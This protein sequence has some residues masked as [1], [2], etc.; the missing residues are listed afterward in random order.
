MEEKILVLRDET[1]PTFWPG[2]NFGQVFMVET[3]GHDQGFKSELEYS[4]S[5]PVEKRLLLHQQALDLL[6]A[7]EQQR[8]QREQESKRTSEVTSSQ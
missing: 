6:V 2:P 1:H 8:V 3:H 5:L 7:L 4:L